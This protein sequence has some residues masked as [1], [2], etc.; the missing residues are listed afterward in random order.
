LW[1]FESG[2]KSLAGLSLVVGLAI[3]RAVNGHSR[4]PTRLK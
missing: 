4:Y 1:R 3:A 2:L